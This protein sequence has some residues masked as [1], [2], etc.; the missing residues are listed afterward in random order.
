MANLV[1]DIG[2][3]RIKVAVFDLGQ[4]IVTFPTEELRSKHLQI[5]KNDYPAIDRVI[6]SSVRE[7]DA[8]LLKSLKKIFTSVIELNHSTPLPIKNC[9]DTPET[10]GKDRIAAAVGANQLYPNNNL[11]IID[12]GTAI[13]YDHV[14]EKNEYLGGFITPGLRMRFNALHQY[15]SKLP[16]LNPEFFEAYSGLNTYE[17]IQGGIQYGLEGEIQRMVSI[18]NS[19]GKDFKIILTG[20]DANY[21]E[22]LVKSYKFV[23]LELTLIGLNRIL[24]FNHPF[25]H[26]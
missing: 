26:E 12:A 10:L 22:K 8:W 19:N 20:G 5:L 11:M 4:L 25:Y 23:A 16:L 7:H 13:T 14:N 1:I 15:T 2:N 18:F 9:Y 24:E 6:V 3:T 21:F 17:S